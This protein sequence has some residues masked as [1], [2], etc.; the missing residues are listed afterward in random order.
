M[1]GDDLRRH[2]LD[3]RVRANRIAQKIIG[4]AYPGRY[5]MDA[6]LGT[7]IARSAGLARQVQVRPVQSDDAEPDD[8]FARWHTRVDWPVHLI[9]PGDLVLMV[10]VHGFSY[11]VGVLDHGVGTPTGVALGAA[12]SSTPDPAVTGT[13]DDGQIVLGPT[14]GSGLAVG[15]IMTLTFPLARPS[16][17]FSVLLLPA[18]GSART[19]GAVLGRSARS[20]TTVT[21]ATGT[22]L[23]LGS[24]Y[25]W[26]YR[27]Q[28]YA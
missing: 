19:L 12:G 8:V 25:V 6:W 7:V 17:S 20:N 28:Q 2:V 18:S 9:Y 14:S 1:D 22:A 16:S 3:G 24:T 11:C 10:D 4:V 27:F 26:D 23:T 13:E 5:P 15:D 21:I